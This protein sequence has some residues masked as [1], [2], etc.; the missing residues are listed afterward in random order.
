MR[1]TGS[2][3]AQQDAF[4]PFVEKGSIVLIAPLQKNPSFEVECGA[5]FQVPGI[6]AEGFGR[7][8]FGKILTNALNSPAGLKRLRMSGL[9]SSRAG[10]C[11]VCQ[12]G[13]QN[14]AEY[15]GD[16]GA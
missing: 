14:G 7:D 3:K 12:R 2:I 10:H 5:S 13:C 1:F 4:L 11:G 9:R 6:R 16:G 15:S 8:G